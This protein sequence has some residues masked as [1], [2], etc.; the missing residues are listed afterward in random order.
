MKEV[1]KEKQEREKEGGYSEAN[2]QDFYQ[3]RFLFFH[4]KIERYILRLH[5]VQRIKNKRS[6]ENEKIK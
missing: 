2:V 6:N 5:R 4:A 1:Q 3:I